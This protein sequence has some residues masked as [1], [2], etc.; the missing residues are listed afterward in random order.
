[1]DEQPRRPNGRAFFTNWGKAMPLGQK[2]SMTAL[3]FWR[4]VVLRRGCCGHP[5][6]PGC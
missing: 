2:I 3:N 5:G 1:M 4:R 6:E